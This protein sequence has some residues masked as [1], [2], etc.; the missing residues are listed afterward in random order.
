MAA[1]LLCFVS[2]RTFKAENATQISVEAQLLERGQHLPS[3][4]RKGL[5]SQNTR[6]IS[7][8]FTSIQTDHVTVNLEGGWLM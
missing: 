7:V 6:S 2:Q 1:K 8:V 4:S 3:T 5:G